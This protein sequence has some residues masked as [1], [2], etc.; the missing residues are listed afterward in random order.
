[1]ENAMFG[2]RKGLNG[3]GHERAIKLQIHPENLTVSLH[4]PPTKSVCKID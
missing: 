4:Y 1:M 3:I 2:A